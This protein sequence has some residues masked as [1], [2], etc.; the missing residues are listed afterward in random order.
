MLRLARQYGIV[1]WWSTPV[2][3]GSAFARLLRSG[4]LTGAEL[5]LAEKSLERLRGAWQEVRPDDAL[6]SEAETL[7]HRFALT[8]ADAFQLA[9]A[10][11]WAGG[12]PQNRPFICGDVRLLEAARQLGFHAIEA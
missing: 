3:A 6:R 12:H 11:I 4:A 9:A 1:V 7:L 5:A 10:L 8:A 2:E